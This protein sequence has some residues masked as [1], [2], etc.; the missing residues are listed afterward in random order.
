MNELDHF[1]VANAARIP[2]TVRTLKPFWLGSDLK[3]WVHSSEISDAILYLAAR[4]GLPD[5]EIRALKELLERL[6]SSL[7]EKSASVDHHP[8]PADLEENATSGQ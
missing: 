8:A 1:V 7:K 3:P 4:T 2:C 5:E 6:S